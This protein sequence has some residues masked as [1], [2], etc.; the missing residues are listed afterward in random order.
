MI[1]LDALINEDRLPQVKLCGKT[2]A[3]R[4]LTAA[5]AHRVATVTAR[6]T[7]GTETLAVMME[8]VRQAVPA[9]TS[10]DIA[11]LTVD[12][13]GAIIQLSR[14][15]VDAVEESLRAQAKAGAE[16]NG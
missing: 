6:D 9:L 3:V 10:E 8:L 14:G 15:Q 13:I 12:Q 16:G 11:T 7:S 2:M 5:M 1:D 4:P